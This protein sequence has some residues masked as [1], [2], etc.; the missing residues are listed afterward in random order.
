MGVRDCAGELGLQLGV[1]HLGRFSPPPAALRAEIAPARRWFVIED[2]VR[3]G[4]V[5]DQAA[6]I[7]GRQPD[8]WF[9]WPADWGGGSGSS[10]ELR[11]SCHLG[12]REVAATIVA[13]WG[14][15]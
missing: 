15:A 13:Q 14:D 6:N 12:D 2:H 11:E 4:G 8:A 7:V 1:L 9:G 5:A 3:L 10:I